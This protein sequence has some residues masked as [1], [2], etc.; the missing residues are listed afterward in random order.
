MFT[1]SLD[2]KQK[3]DVTV[4]AVVVED[5]NKPAP[6]PEPPAWTVSDPAVIGFTPVDGHPEEVVVRPLAAGAASLKCESGAIVGTV[7]FEVPAVVV[8]PVA[9]GLVFD[10]VVS[11]DTE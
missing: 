2:P 8:V 7:D 6:F 4:R 11:D 9:T 1:L 3:G 5:G 10:V